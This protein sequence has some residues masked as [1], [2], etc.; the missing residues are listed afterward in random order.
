[1]KCL[2]P[3]PSRGP[4]VPG[5]AGA[6]TKAFTQSGALTMHAF[7]LP[8]LG[9]MPCENH[10]STPALLFHTDA[11]RCCVFPALWNIMWGVGVLL[12]SGMCFFTLPLPVPS[13]CDHPPNS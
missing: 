8:G 5:G 3:V 4:W 6:A 1:M 13:F 2:G 9:Q 12:W 10:T 7:A 11:A